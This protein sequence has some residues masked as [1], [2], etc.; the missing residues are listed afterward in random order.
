VLAWIGG[1]IEQQTMTPLLVWAMA[2]IGTAKL[3]T[4]RA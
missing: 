4:T 3:K 2:L 1:E